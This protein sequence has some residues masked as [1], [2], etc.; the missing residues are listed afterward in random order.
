[1][2]SNKAWIYVLVF[3]FPS[4]TFAQ[5]KANIDSIIY[6][7]KCYFQQD[8]DYE[9]ITEQSSPSII[10]Y[11]SI[12]NN[13]KNPIKLIQSS[14]P[15]IELRYFYR[16]KPAYPGNYYYLKANWLNKSY[17]DEDEI[18]IAPL[19]IQPHQVTPLIVWARPTI[20]EMNIKQDSFLLQNQYTIKE[21][22]N[23][24]YEI[25]KNFKVVIYYGYET[26]TPKILLSDY[27]NKK[28]STI[29]IDIE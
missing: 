12:T 1:M 11:L 27:F 29:K 21:L 26:G 4:V 3:L 9:K 25:I 7:D 18:S 13:T 23:W 22:E 16:F 10:I 24:F 2:K 20:K 8:L 19:I 15:K 17:E 14:N 28:Y 5:L 6:S